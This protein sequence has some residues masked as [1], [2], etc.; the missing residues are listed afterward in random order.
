M[1]S[2]GWQT[3]LH[4]YACCGVVLQGGTGSQQIVIEGP[5]CEDYYKIREHL[6]SQFYLL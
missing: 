5:L 1:V 4:S 2:R 3:S 6:Y